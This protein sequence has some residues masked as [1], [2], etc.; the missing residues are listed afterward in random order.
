MQ[1]NLLIQDVE[2]SFDT[3]KGKLVCVPMPKHAQVLLCFAEQMNIPFAKIKLHSADR[4]KDA[5][6]VLPDAAALGD[7][8][9]QRWN[10]YPAL[11][12]HARQRSGLH[13]GE[14][15]ELRRGLQECATLLGLGVAASPADV[16]NALRKRLTTDH[17]KLQ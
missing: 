2:G 6:Q 11:K 10:D 17:G 5:M 4:Y 7:E 13:E 1:I 9:A 3:E 16:V 15:G 14:S 8:I 12:E